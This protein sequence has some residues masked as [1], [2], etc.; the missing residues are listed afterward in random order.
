MIFF[1]RESFCIL[2][3]RNNSKILDS[4]IGYMLRKYSSRRLARLAAVQAIYQSLQTEDSLEDIISHFKNYHFTQGVLQSRV[5]PH[6][7]LFESIVWGVFNHTELLKETITRHLQKDWRLDR[8]AYL[9]LSLLLCA[10]YELCYDKALPHSIVI[11]EYIEISKE[12]LDFSD[13]RFIN[14]ILDIISK[15]DL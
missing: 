12:F 8:L 11:N 2:D 14:G 10:V 9:S 7:E 1:R 6:I 15:E 4:Y 13:T 5:P 3:E